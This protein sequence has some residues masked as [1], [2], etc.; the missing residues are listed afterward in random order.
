MSAWNKNLADAPRDEQLL[1]RLPEWDCP[2][3]VRY[4][5]HNGEGW[6]EFCE[7]LLSD[8]AGDLGQDAVDRAEWARLPE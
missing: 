8:A 1:V 2:A 4:A 5:T 3:I 6:W 7:E